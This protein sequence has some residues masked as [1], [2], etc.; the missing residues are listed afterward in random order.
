MR[1]VSDCMLKSVL[2]A[3]VLA[4]LATPALAQTSLD[5]S[6]IGVVRGLESQNT[7]GQVGEVLFHASNL[8]LD[9][10]GTGGKSE[11]VTINRSFQCSDRS[12]P[13]AATLGTLSN[14]MLT[15]TATIS[16][17]RLLSGN[18]V[19]VVHNNGPMSR[20]VACGQLYRS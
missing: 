20:P 6:I 9:V 17:D 1:W 7:S 10:K 3:A 5:Q 14:G 19:V 2:V 11:A 15:A 16:N 12:G 4:A 13:I 18:Y 8:M